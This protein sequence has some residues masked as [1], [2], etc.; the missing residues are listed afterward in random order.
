MQDRI[1]P[2]Y[3]HW[4]W[5]HLHHWSG[6]IEGLWNDSW[7]NQIRDTNDKCTVWPEKAKTLVFKC[8]DF[9]AAS[10][11]CKYLTTISYNICEPEDFT[12]TVQHTQCPDQEWNCEDYV[13]SNWLWSFADDGDLDPLEEEGEEFYDFW[14]NAWLDGDLD[15][16]DDAG[17]PLPDDEYE[18]PEILLNS[19]RRTVNGLNT[20]SGIV[21]VDLDD[22]H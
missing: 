15:E 9:P 19:D 11:N 1:L 2:F 6:H 18:R 5:F 20:I 16:F 12:C 14:Y 22:A 3:N 8:S 21:K 7:D 10:Q 17:D 13:S 4:V